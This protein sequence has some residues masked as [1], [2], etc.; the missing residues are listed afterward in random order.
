MAPQK[1]KVTKV[2]SK[3]DRKKIADPLI[4]Y[5]VARFGES[6]REK[7]A[8]RLCGDDGEINGGL[9][10]YTA[11]DWLYIEMLF[12]PED[13]RGKGMA[14]TLLQMAEDEAKRRG[15]IGAFIDTMSPDALGVYRRYGYETIGSLGE[16]AG[17]HTFTWLK[18]R[19]Q[20]S[21]A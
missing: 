20:P 18:K 19:F 13:M 21:E 9:V 1:L 4:A 16:F 11:R 17:G 2:L 8:I 5:N 3:K 12:V 14:G 6:G 10:G 15:C 7:L